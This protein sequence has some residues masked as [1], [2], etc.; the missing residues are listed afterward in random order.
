MQSFFI[1]ICSDGEE[2]RNLLYAG[3]PLSTH[4]PANLI[5]AGNEQ[6]GDKN[7]STFYLFHVIL[8][9]QETNQ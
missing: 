3:D 1:A 8:E 5:V 6:H 2:A 7:Q 4:N 9:I